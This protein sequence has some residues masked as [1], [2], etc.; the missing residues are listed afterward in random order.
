[1]YGNSPEGISGAPPVSALSCLVEHCAVDSGVAA[2][3]LALDTLKEDRMELGRTFDYTGPIPEGGALLIEDFAT[4]LGLAVGDTLYITLFMPLTIRNGF[5]PEVGRSVVGDHYINDTGWATASLAY[6]EVSVPL[7]VEGILSTPQGKLGNTRTATIM[8]EFNSL[9]PHLAQHMHPAVRPL[10]APGADTTVAGPRA[11]RRSLLAEAASSVVVNLP[12][13]KRIDAYLSSNYDDL[14]RELTSFASTLMYVVGFSQSSSS[15]PLLSELSG[16]RF[17]SLYLGLL[18]DILLVILFFLCSIL[19]YSLL[20]INV[21]A[22][23][24]ELAVRRMLGTTRKGVMGL[25]VLQALFY[26]IPAWIIGLSA[27]AGVATQLLAAFGNV[28]GIDPGSGLSPNAVGVATAMAF[29]IPLAGS[30]GPIRAAL[31]TSIREALDLDRPKASAVEY[32]LERSQDG[33]VS[34]ALLGFGVLITVFGFC[35][36]YL[37]PLALLSLNLALFFNIFFWILIGML[38]G[39]VLLALNFEVTLE[40][41]LTYALLA[42][43]EKWAILQLSLANLVA[44]R[45]RNRKTTIMYALS[46]AFI[47]FITVAANQEVQSA[48]FLVQQRAGAPIT[49]QPAEPP[50]LSELEGSP[51]EATMARMDAVLASLK[52]RGLVR[53]HSWRSTRWSGATDGTTVSNPS[54]TNLGR[55]VDSIGVQPRAVSPEFWDATYPQYTVLSAEDARSGLPLAEQYYTAR[56]SQGASLPSFYEQDNALAADVG[57]DATMQTRGVV[58]TGDLVAGGADTGGAFSLGGGG[59]STVTRNRVRIHNLFDA[60]SGLNFSPFAS[61]ANTAVFGLPSLLQLLAERGIFET[62]RSVYYWRGTVMPAEGKEGDDATLDQIKAELITVAA[63]GGWGVGDVR[64]EVEDLETILLVLNFFFTTLTVLTLMLCFFSLLAS[65]ITNIQEQQK[66]IGVLL[67]VGLKYVLH[68]PTLPRMLLFTPPHTICRRA[69]HLIRVYIYE[70]FVLVVSASIMGTIIGSI[71]AWTFSQQR[72]LFT[73]VRL[74]RACMTPA[75]PTPLG[76]FTAAHGILLSL[77]H[78]GHC[79]HSVCHCSAAV[80]SAACKASD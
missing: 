19:I 39:M 4:Q 62:P 45:R 49:I 9:V 44:H 22:R 27:A 8:V 14:Q 28:A 36:Y 29:A 53:E 50:P 15:Q 61:G 16:R 73:Q 65:M 57:D 56:G 55:V 60:S 5:E 33:A 59:S 24:F 64:D 40:R 79:D 10:T 1:M 75:Q 77:A 72:T 32:K 7:R 26:A 25:L 70:A 23:T 20:M 68:M 51:Y 47:V 13:S 76:L 67:A 54:L 69:W 48:T 42:W 2:N 17:V 18:L 52:A 37:L 74:R 31:G 66:E 41:V 11:S 12:P 46:L 34:P 71:V 43:W 58:E 30:I 80:C 38:L 3:V 35:I 78:F 21:N 6:P 63:P